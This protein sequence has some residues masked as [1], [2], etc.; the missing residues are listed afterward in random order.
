MRKSDAK[1]EEKL[2]CCF[3]MIIIWWILTWAIEIPQSFTLICPFCTNYLK[4]DLRKYRGVIFYDNEQWCKIWR[5]TD[6]LFG[7]WHKK[8]GKFWPEHFKVSKLGFWRDPFIQTRKCTSLMFTKKL[9]IIKMKDDAKFEEELTCRFKINTKIWWILTKHSKVSKSC[10]LMGSFW[11]TY[12][13]F[14]LKNT[15]ELCFMTLK[16]DLKKTWLVVWKSTRKSQNCDFDGVLLSKVE[17]AWGYNL[18][19]IYVA[20]QWRMVQNL[21]RNWICVWKL[22]PQ[23][24]KFWPGHSNVPKMWTLI[25]SIW[26]KYIMFE[27]KKYRRYMF[28]GTED[29]CKI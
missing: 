28:D 20:W 9:C 4:F 10:T 16:S 21:K 26:T 29:W 22:V 17:N 1:F 14:Q 7:K 23:F 11:A 3:K 12:I 18:L 19:R 8:Y 27:L 25:S 15:D 24:D 5:K 2:T 6:L 13:M